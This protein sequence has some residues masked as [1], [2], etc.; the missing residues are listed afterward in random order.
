MMQLGPGMYS[1]KSGPCDECG[2]K[3]EQI[4]EKKK[5]KT[6]M[7]KKLKKETKKLKVTIDKGAPH[8]EKYTIHGEG[9][10]MPGAETGDV[11]V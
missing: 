8:G 7:G 5:C 9:E 11:I 3:G 6:C 2:G 10:E 4:D 1:Q